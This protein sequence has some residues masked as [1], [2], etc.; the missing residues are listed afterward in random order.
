MFLT[1]ASLA[2]IE[3]CLQA[4]AERAQ[5]LEQLSER[6]AGWSEQPET[7]WAAERALHVGIECV[8]DA[9]NELIDALVMR[10]PGGYADILRVLI[11]EGVLKREWFER[12]TGALDLRQ[13]LVRH[14][15]VLEPQ[16][17]EQAARE[18]SPMLLEY[19]EQM[20]AYITRER[21]L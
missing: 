19:V 1:D 6:P 20:R 12:F 8:T 3:Q 11:E 2:R 16:R 5:W 10:E 15:L 17:V 4:V 9:A 14:Y 13:E 7:R 21:G 18:Y